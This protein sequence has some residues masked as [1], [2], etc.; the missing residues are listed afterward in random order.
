[1][2]HPQDGYGGLESHVRHNVDD[3]RKVAATRTAADQQDKPKTI[4]RRKSS[5]WNEFQALQNDRLPKGPQ[6][7]RQ[8]SSVS[9]TSTTSA[10]RMSQA[11]RVSFAPLPTRDDQSSVL[12]TQCVCNDDDF[13]VDST[14]TIEDTTPREEATAVTPR[15]H[16][17]PIYPRDA[18]P[19]LYP[20]INNGRE[21]QT[22]AMHPYD[23]DSGQNAHEMEAFHWIAN[24]RMIKDDL[25]VRDREAPS[26]GDYHIVQS[27]SG[28]AYVPQYRL[29]ED[30][31][32][33]VPSNGPP[34]QQKFYPPAQPSE[35]PS[36]ERRYIRP[37]Q[38]EPDRRTR[39]EQ[40]HY[41]PYHN[42]VDSNRD[43]H[44]DAR[45][46]RR[47]RQPSPPPTPR[48]Q[49]MQQQFMNYHA[50]QTQGQHTPHGSQNPRIT[51]LQKQRETKGI[52]SQEYVMSKTF[53]YMGNT[54]NDDQNDIPSSITVPS[55]GGGATNT[56]N[57]TAT[58]S[59]GSSSYLNSSHRYVVNRNEVYD[60]Y[61][62]ST[63]MYSLS[64]GAGRREEG[65]IQR[66]D[67]NND[68]IIIS[69]RSPR[70]TMGYAG[71]SHNFAEGDIE[72]NFIVDNDDTLELREQV[73]QM[74]V[75]DHTDNNNNNNGNGN[76][77]NGNGNN[78]SRS[79][80]QRRDRVQR[81]QRQASVSTMD[82]ASLTFLSST[83]TRGW[84]MT[85]RTKQIL[86]ILL[87]I[88][89]T[90]LVSVIIGYLLYYY[91]VLLL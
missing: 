4:L 64:G 34:P 25:E 54:S 19:T 8:N 22:R 9:S 21:V 53:L 47:W 65:D 88:L 31:D 39:N 32:R 83:T 51:R 69:S 7:A 20:D 81:I 10:S 13:S 29:E 78:N 11:K 37:R 87:V 52:S 6:N 66:I 85:T 1:M 18:P 14:C 15:H 44:H 23:D 49:Q 43:R 72:S 57:S 91:G 33:E 59:Q 2:K 62:D 48:A 58:T 42:V 67:T 41:T 80:P 45:Q 89:S 71:Y 86:F 3:D 56:T 26:S 38:P 77:N 50:N 35:V 17:E 40:Y 79:N 68:R 63:I 12:S 30:R 70:T 24:E 46:Q 73:L 55:L 28:I 90:F 36:H 60:G 74:A 84:I 27:G 82:T 76:R 75:F 5:I 16:E 61:D